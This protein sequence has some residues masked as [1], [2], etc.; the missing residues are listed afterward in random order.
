M[1]FEGTTWATCRT[2][3]SGNLADRRA[4]GFGAA[5]D[6]LDAVGLDAIE[7]HDTSCRIH[8]LV[9]ASCVDRALGPPP[10]RRAGI[11]SFNVSGIHPHDVAQVLY[12][13][14][15]RF[16]QATTFVSR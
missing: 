13:G 2:S 8:T 15:W 1:E 9:S 14:A 11:V 7:Q 12:F 16:A 5:V 10:E 3:S 6:Y 4:V